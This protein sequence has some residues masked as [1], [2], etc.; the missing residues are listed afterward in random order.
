AA[1]LQFMQVYLAEERPPTGEAM[2][3][4]DAKQDERS[5]YGVFEI[6]EDGAKLM[7]YELLINPP[8]VDS[9]PL[10]WPWERVREELKK[11]EALGQD[12]AGRR[13][14]LLYN[15][16]TGRANGTTPSFFATITMRPPRIIDRPHR[17]VS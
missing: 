4:A 14:Y 3:V 9:R 13:L 5:P 11:L 15:P 17:H 8:T 12:Y 16:T 10:F 2:R 7:P 6:G 1:L